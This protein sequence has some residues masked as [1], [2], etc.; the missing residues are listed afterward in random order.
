MTTCP[1]AFKMIEASNSVMQVITSHS[2]IPLSRM[3][4][5]Q[6]RS[7]SISQAMEL[8]SLPA[9]SRN[10]WT[11]SL[12]A[13]SSTLFDLVRLFSSLVSR[14]SSALLQ[15]PHKTSL[16]PCQSLWISLTVFAFSRYFVPVACAHGPL[17]KHAPQRRLLRRLQVSSPGTWPAH[18]VR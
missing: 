8:S 18:P 14:A 16:S 1:D 3:T 13:S 10:E 15:C 2:A 11:F 4:I 7:S 17:A 12:M 6:A 5:S 9:Q